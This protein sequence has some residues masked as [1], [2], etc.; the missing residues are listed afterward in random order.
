MSKCDGDKRKQHESDFHDTKRLLDEARQRRVALAEQNKEMEM[1]KKR[2]LSADTPTVEK[3][4]K[5]TIST[6][7]VSSSKSQNNSKKDRHIS[8]TK[9]TD[10]IFC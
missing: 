8:E 10:V 7:K 9:V 2:K 5:S 6:P 4:K 1:K 3:I